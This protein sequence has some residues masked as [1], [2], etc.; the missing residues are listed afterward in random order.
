MVR[1]VLARSS[2]GR[3]GDPLEFDVVVAAAA[4]AEVDCY[5]AK[6]D[7]IGMVG[8]TLD[9]TMDLVHVGCTID[10]ESERQWTIPSVHD[11]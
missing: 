8:Y 2:W 3:W 10:Q 1:Y 11:V 4:A 6:R 5:R 7:G 9:L